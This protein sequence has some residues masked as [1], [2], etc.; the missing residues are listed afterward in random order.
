MNRKTLFIP[1]AALI[2]TAIGVGAF[3]QTVLERAG[4]S[5]TQR[6]AVSEAA[7]LR[8]RG[9]RTAARD[10][11]VEAGIGIDELERLR[12]EAMRAKYRA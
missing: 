10:L 11:L 5:S 6:V 12:L 3:S 7:E 4:L 9:D 8:R 2:L 1:A